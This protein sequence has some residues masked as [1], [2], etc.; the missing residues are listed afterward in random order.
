[1]SKGLDIKTIKSKNK[2]II[3]QTEA[4]KQY[5]EFRGINIYF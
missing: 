4:P 1:M 5:I 2:K 3:V